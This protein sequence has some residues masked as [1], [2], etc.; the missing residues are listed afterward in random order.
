MSNKLDD[1]RKAGKLIIGKKTVL[2]N[3]KSGGLAGVVYSS[4]CPKNLL[5]DLSYYSKLNK[6]EIE[7][8]N[9]NSEKLGEACGKPFNV[10][11]V[12]IK[13]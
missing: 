10:L 8:F 6:I 3:L 13:K 5:E 4:N 2:K 11:V 12:G 7:N 9:D 1:A